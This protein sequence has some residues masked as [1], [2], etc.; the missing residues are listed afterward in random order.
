MALVAAAAAM[1]GASYGVA[2]AHDIHT[3]VLQ[4]TWAPKGAALSGTLRIFADD[5]S[6][7]ARAAKVTPQAYVLRGLQLRVSGAAVP[8]ALCGEQRIG[9]AVLICVRGAWHGAGSMR[10]KNTLLLERYADQVNIV[11]VEAARVVT[12]LFTSGASER[13]VP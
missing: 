13:A 5:L 12:L 7:A 1:F 9:D 4:L 3:T 6:N 11:R 8:L 2:E 10:L